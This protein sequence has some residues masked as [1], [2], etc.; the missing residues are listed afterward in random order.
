MIYSTERWRSTDNDCG[1]LNAVAVEWVDMIDSELGR[2]MQ[3]STLGEFEYQTNLTEH[4]ERLVI[5]SNVSNE[6]FITNK[7]RTA[8]TARVAFTN[9]VSVVKGHSR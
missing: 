8:E 4:N 1:E 6:V 9:P 7:L 3:A 5:V 2:Y